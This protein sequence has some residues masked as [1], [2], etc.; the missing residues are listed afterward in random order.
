[1]SI[2]I[3]LFYRFPPFCV[4]FTAWVQLIWKFENRTPYYLYSRMYLREFILVSFLSGG[5]DPE[6]SYNEI[7]RNDTHGLLSARHY[8]FKR[9]EG[10]KKR[11]RVPVNPRERQAV[12]GRV[13]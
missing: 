9:V 12:F 1:M 10:K 4:S 3:D 11:N 13:Q 7:G 5:P 2:S 6:N 8:D